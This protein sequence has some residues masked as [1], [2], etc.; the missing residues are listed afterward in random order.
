MTLLSPFGPKTWACVYSS[1]GFF[2]D[3][4]KGGVRHILKYA[5]DELAHVLVADTWNQAKNCRY[6]L[7]PPG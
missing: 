7:N 2:Y 4:G 3:Q 1:H 6:I 5:G